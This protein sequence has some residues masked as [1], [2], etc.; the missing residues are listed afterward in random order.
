MSHLVLKTNGIFEAEIYLDKWL[1]CARR[2]QIP[3]IVK[4][5]KS[6]HKHHSDGIFQWFRNRVNNGILEGINGLI[7][8]AK[9]QASGYRSTKNPYSHDLSNCSWLDLKA[10]TYAN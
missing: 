4:V 6:I 2:S 3:D 7:Q 8:T 5:V 10:Y 1:S 9:R